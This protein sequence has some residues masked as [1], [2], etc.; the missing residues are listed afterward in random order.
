[1]KKFVC[2]AALCFLLAAT[3]CLA[4]GTATTNP[5]G[6]EHIVEGGHEHDCDAPAQ[7]AAIHAEHGAGH[8]G[9]ATSAQENSNEG[10]AETCT[11]ELVL[12]GRLVHGE[13]MACGPGDGPGGSAGCSYDI[14]L[15]CGGT[16]R[17]H[18]F[19]AASNRTG[20]LPNC[21]YA[22]GNYGCTSDTTGDQYCKCDS[23]SGLI[24]N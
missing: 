13:W 18:H 4:N 10:S 14:V 17:S 24:C 19:G 9:N 5:G 15:W 23:S 11:D 7:G 1:M 6:G 12:N 3:P 2:A 8:C 21:G 22:D 20:V 16:L